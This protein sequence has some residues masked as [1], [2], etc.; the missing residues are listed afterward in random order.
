[1]IENNISNHYINKNIIIINNNNIDNK[2]YN[3]TIKFTCNNILS[4][5]LTKNK[6]KNSLNLLTRT[7]FLRLILLIL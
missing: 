5:T 4:I 6:I 7:D 1:M 3:N 2:K